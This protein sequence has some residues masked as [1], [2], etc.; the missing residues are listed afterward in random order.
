VRGQRG[1]IK[2]SRMYKQY[3]DDIKMKNFIDDIIEIYKK[4]NMSLSH[5]DAHGCFEVEELTEY[6]IKWLK[7]ADGKRREEHD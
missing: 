2:M 4:H 3:D 5:E 1:E 6:N 7:E